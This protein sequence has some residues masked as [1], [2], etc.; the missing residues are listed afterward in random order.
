MVLT[1]ACDQMDWGEVTE[2]K[3]VDQGRSM[4]G[5][6]P[7]GVFAARTEEDGWEDER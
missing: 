3:T 5:A 1:L 4:F 7:R 2:A 6:T